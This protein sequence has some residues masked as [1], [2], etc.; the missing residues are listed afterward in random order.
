MSLVYEHL[1]PAN[2][3]ATSVL[4]S[5]P[6]YAQVRKWAELQEL[7]GFF[8]P[9]LLTLLLLLDFIAELQELPVGCDGR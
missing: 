8:S 5:Y 4:C 2:Q 9:T 7:Q 1:D 3:S 6:R